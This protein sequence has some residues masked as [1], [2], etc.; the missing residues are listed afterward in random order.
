[1]KTIIKAIIV[2]VVLLLLA[3][4]AGATKTIYAYD[5][6][7]RPDSNVIGDG[8]IQSATSEIGINSSA[9]NISTI[10]RRSLYY[11]Y[12]NTV[13]ANISFTIKDFD[14]NI[15][16]SDERFTFRFHVQTNGTGAYEAGYHLILSPNSTRRTAILVF[17]NGTSGGTRTIQSLSS[18]DFAYND[19]IT[20]ETSTV[21]T[22]LQVYKNNISY[23]SFTGDANYTTG[24]FGFESTNTPSGENMMMDDLEFWIN[25][26]DPIN[27]P[28][29]LTDEWN[30]IKGTQIQ[31]LINVSNNIEFGISSN[32]T[33]NITWY[34]DGVLNQ[35]NTTIT[36]A[37]YTTSWS[38]SSSVV[39]TVMAS[40]N[41]ENGTSNNVTWYILVYND[42]TATVTFLGVKTVTGASGWTTIP[43]MFKKIN[44]VSRIDYVDNKTFLMKYPMTISSGSTLYVNDTTIDVLRL[45]NLVGGSAVSSSIIGTLEMTNIELNDWNLTTNTYSENLELNK[46]YLSITGTANISNIITNYFGYSTGS[47]CGSIAKAFVFSSGSGYIKNSTLSNTSSIS[48]TDTY[49]IEISNNTINSMFG[50]NIDAIVL[51]RSDNNIINNNNINGGA[52]KLYIYR[53]ITLSNSSN[54]NISNNNIQNTFWSAIVSAGGGS[55]YPAN[56]ND[57]NSNLIHN[58]TINNSRHN[59]IDI[60]HAHNETITN[61]VVY[62]TNASL[63]DAN[64]IYLGSGDCSPNPAY[65]CSV[66]DITILNNTAYNFKGSAFYVLGYNISY[67]DN[68]GYLSG[69][70]FAIDNN[71]D[72]NISSNITITNF[73]G[74][75]SITSGDIYVTIANKDISFLNSNVTNFIG[76]GNG[77]SFNSY[78]YLDINVTDTT[79][80]IIEDATIT[81]SNIT[82]SIAI[83]FSN[84]TTTTTLL[85]GH[86]PLPNQSNA[87]SIAAYY[88]NATRQ[89]RSYNVSVSRSGYITNNS[90]IISADESWYRSDPNTYQNTT[91]IIL[92]EAE[93][94]YSISGYV[95]DSLGAAIET[96][97]I[98]NGTNST[99]TNATGYYTILMTNGTYNF[100][101]TKTG[102]VTGYKEI[103]IDGADVMNQN[104]TLTSSASVITIPANSWGI[105]NNWSENTNF[106][107]IAANESNDVAFT[108]YNVTTGEWEQYAPGYSWNADYTIDKN[109]SVMGFFN[110]ETTITATTVTPWNT[111]IIAGWNML[112]LMGTTNQTLTA[113]CTN[114]VNC[115]DIY[116]YNSTTNDYVSTGTDT[117]QPNQGFLAY[118]NQT[119]TWIRS[120]F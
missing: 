26:A 76:S 95:N 40:M 72:N 24:W 108:F 102:Y 65:N 78:Y 105:F 117:I 73:T 56:L 8:W 18:V 83:N 84:L 90:V 48:I 59:A 79:G 74:Y 4:T 81:V 33:G 21:T 45:S 36:T 32:Q 53:G 10:A 85:N 66:S 41:N 29:S 62:L 92:T 94:T 97:S 49:K 38:S 115:T 43:D 80:D 91:T 9:L 30:S 113:I 68:I 55:S 60:H 98:V 1:M 75:G 20:I 104:V 54:N 39:K 31:T 120:S 51:L 88:Y 22:G 58:N 118:V 61:N 42:G 37:N 119:G 3:G 57:S 111:S 16:N 47:C 35:T 89:N 107:S 77:G 17:Q 103:I 100:S 27:P 63:T 116:Y 23:L 101:Y 110:A 6:F 46:D 109:Y 2:M 82:S 34:K 5:Y 13:N 44:N 93:P 96:V 11:A 28:A 25:S 67:K 71:V 7:D 64:G 50:T 99:T 14:G 15:S 19:Y 87:I 106:S 114:M 70:N 112:Y 69:K 86:I 12:N 52:N